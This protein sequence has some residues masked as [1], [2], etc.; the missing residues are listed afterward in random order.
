MRVVINTPNGHIGR[1]LARDLLAAGI[2]TVGIARDPSKVADL[3]GLQVV[4]GSIEDAA[5]LDRAFEGADALF[6]LTPP[7]SSPDYLDRSVANARRAA[8]A[9]K[10]HGV[11]RAVVLSST[12]AHSG[13]GTGPVG[14]MLAVED[15]FRA[16]LPDV[17]ALR[18]G[19]FME[20]FLYTVG[21]IAQAGAI[22]QTNPPDKKVPMVA[23]ADIAAKAAEFLKNG[24]SG[25][26]T[27]GVHGPADV[28]YR[29]ATAIISETIGRP[30]NYVQVTVDQARQA[31]AQ[32]GMPGFVVDLFAEMYQAI[33]DG[34]MDPAEPRTAES[35][36]PTTFASFAKT[37]LRPAI[38][39]ARA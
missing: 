33:L 4:Q 25:H 21:T 35:T 17:V 23:T 37:V 26:R 15:A 27:V 28:S 38:E 6:W 24:W 39:A 3:A 29:E 8:E 10:R 9:A 32:M 14:A 2:Q 20:N 1:A 22:F 5:T 12:G 16:A 11:R 19:F 36:T 7:A 31:M 18:A 13:P 34:R 30:V